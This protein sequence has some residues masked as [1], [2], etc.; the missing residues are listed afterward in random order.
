MIKAFTD[1]C[2]RNLSGMTRLNINVSIKRP[3]RGAAGM[4]GIASVMH[5]NFSRQKILA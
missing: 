5:N 4:A 3:L 2:T 1:L